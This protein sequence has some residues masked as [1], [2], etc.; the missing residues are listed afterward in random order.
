MNFFIFLVLLLLLKTYTNAILTM[1]AH[2]LS[3]IHI[4]QVPA[5]FASTEKLTNYI[6]N[7]KCIGAVSHVDIVKRKDSETYMAFVHFKCPWNNGEVSNVV[8]RR[9]SVNGVYEERL[10]SGYGYLNWMPKGETLQFRLIRSDS[11]QKKT[12]MDVLLE[13][14]ELIHRLDT[15][16]IEAQSALIA[17]LIKELAEEREKNRVMERKWN[18]FYK[19]ISGVMDWMDMNLANISGV[20]NLLSEE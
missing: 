2:Y 9:I 6:E 4:P 12:D 11:S 5:D 18:G 13:Q 17:Q 10:Q 16:K 15:V 7:Y 20:D 14:T 1:T 8:R 19:T 3:A